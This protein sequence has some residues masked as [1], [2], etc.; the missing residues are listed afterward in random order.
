MVDFKV[1]R[2]LP[3]VQRV[4]KVLKD[5]KVFQGKRDFKEFRDKRVHREY[6]AFKDL[7]MVQ[8]VH[9]GLKDHRV[10]QEL[11]GPKVFQV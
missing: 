11:P 3:M 7:P 9:K 2:V 1:H 5:P 8:P 6:K 4:H 10:F